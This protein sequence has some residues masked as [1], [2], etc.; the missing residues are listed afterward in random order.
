MREIVTG[1]IL[2]LQNI[3]VP[4]WISE[5]VFR[6]PIPHLGDAAPGV[7][8]EARHACAVFV[9]CELLI[10]H[11]KAGVPHADASATIRAGPTLE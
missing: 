9:L 5:F 1:R 11:T 4:V 3:C 8:S 10:K 6:K 2:A 7:Q